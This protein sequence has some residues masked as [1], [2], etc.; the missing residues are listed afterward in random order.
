MANTQNIHSVLGTTSKELVFVQGTWEI[1]SIAAAGG[2]LIASSECLQTSGFES[3]TC[4]G[5]QPRDPGTPPSGPWGTFSLQ[6]SFTVR[7]AFERFV[8]GSAQ[9]FNIVSDVSLPA[10]DVFEAYVN[11]G[12]ESNHFVTPGQTMLADFIRTDPVT[13]AP[14]AMLDVVAGDPPVQLSLFCAFVGPLA[15]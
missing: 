3:I 8:F 15:P 9:L 6:A 2:H 14:N 10:G 7:D 12:V 13:A 1:P 11:A 5:I 4:L